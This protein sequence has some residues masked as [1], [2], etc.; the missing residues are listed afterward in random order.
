MWPG[1]M[2]SKAR[3]STLGNVS[4]EQHIFK[5]KPMWIIYWNI[6]YIRCLSVSSGSKY[7]NATRWYESNQ[8]SG[9]YNKR[10]RQLYCTT[11]DEYPSKEQYRISRNISAMLIKQEVQRPVWS[12]NK[13][14]RYTFP[15]LKYHIVL[16]NVSCT[17]HSSTWVNLT[18]TIWSA[19][20]GWLNQLQSCKWI[21]I[22]FLITLLTS[23]SF[24]GTVL[25][26]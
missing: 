9:Y 8:N 18:L 5:Q 15:E 23:F 17:S 13:C 2:N 24:T 4:R 7:S 14:G 22:S 6:K 12:L 21:S 1:S 25:L 26:Q 11:S 10:V 3:P 20:Q 16:G 19:K